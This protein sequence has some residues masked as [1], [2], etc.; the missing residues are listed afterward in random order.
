[1]SGN[2]VLKALR[3]QAAWTRIRSTRRSAIFE[4]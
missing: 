3:S 2:M 1:M 4:R